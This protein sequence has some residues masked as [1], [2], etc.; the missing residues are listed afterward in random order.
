MNKKP[1]YCTCG[2]NLA[3][4]NKKE[5]MFL[6]CP[7]CGNVYIKKDEKYKL[8]FSTHKAAETMDILASY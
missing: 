3:Y 7:V 2:G 4:M 1:T 6:V 5:Y 8:L